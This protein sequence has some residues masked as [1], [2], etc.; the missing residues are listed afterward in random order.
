MRMITSERLTLRGTLSVLQEEC[1]L[2]VRCPLGS[3]DLV[4]K[5]LESAAGAE[6]GRCAAGEVDTLVSPPRSGWV[7]SLQ[8]RFG[9]A[10]ERRRDDDL[11]SVSTASTLTRSKTQVD[12]ASLHLALAMVTALSRRRAE[13]LEVFFAKK[14]IFLA[15]PKA[16][17]DEPA[18]ILSVAED[19]QFT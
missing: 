16:S 2:R 1:S 13:P 15:P 19:T 6:L 3:F 9:R 4:A 7:S 10:T 18:I 11:A 12:E 5:G 8:G 14:E 17:Y